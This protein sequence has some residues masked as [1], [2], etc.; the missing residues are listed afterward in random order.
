MAEALHD[1]GRR[2][3]VFLGLFEGVLVAVQSLSETV[4]LGMRMG[5]WIQTPNLPPLWVFPH[6]TI[7]AH[8][9]VLLCVTNAK[10][11]PSRFPQ[12]HVW[13]CWSHYSATH[14]S[15]CPFLSRTK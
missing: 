6:L 5:R 12:V 2:G 14:Q 9:P 13:V 10:L 4:P 11:F 1:A 7:G 3:G 15:P 8:P